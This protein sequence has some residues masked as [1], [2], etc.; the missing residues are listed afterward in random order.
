M[1]G[2]SVSFF[3][4]NYGNIFLNTHSAKS[5]FAAGSAVNYSETEIKTMAGKISYFIADACKLPLRD[6]SVDCIISA[7]FTDVVPFPKVFPE[8]TRVMKK[9]GVFIHFGPL[10]NNFGSIQAMFSAEDI[11]SYLFKY[12]YS[13]LFETVVNAPHMKAAEKMNV[14]SYDNWVY[15]AK[16][17]TGSFEEKNA[18]LSENTILTFEST[19]R[20]SVNGEIGNFGE[21]LHHNLYNTY[22]DKNYDGAEEVIRLLRLIDGQKTLKQIA[23]AYLQQEA[24][25]ENDWLK[26]KSIIVFLMQERILTIR[27]DI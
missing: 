12:G 11:K 8:L 7:Y 19:V 24:G 23:S 9:G 13:G 20:F 6:N 2:N 10:A 21:E 15:A 18:A 3:D 17:T 5:L 1:S 25:N 22:K 16:K 27:E 14:E 4:I 26:I